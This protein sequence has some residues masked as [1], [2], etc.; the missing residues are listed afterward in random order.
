ML[1]KDTET[2]SVTYS[3]ENATEVDDV[4]WS[5]SDE[6]VATVDEE[7]KVTALKEGTATITAKMGNL[8]DTANVTVTEVALTGISL[9]NNKEEMEAGKNFKLNVTLE[10]FNA[11][12]D[13]T[14]T[15]ES[16]DP[17]VAEID[18][19]GN[20]IPK[21][22][23]KVK[24]TVKA[25]NGTSE[26]EETIELEITAPKSPQTGVT[27]IWVYGGI[28]SILLVVALVIYK[29]KELF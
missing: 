2:L 19:E 17:E 15:Y 25:S 20:V 29:K 9:E 28:I 14:Y 16:S 27:P 8:T 10:P 13:V 5:S 6:T 12:D 23:G 26:Y 18:E 24:F 11:T 1:R 22:P 4:I 21:K 3:P 7:G